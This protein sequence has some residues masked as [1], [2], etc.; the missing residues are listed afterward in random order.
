MVVIVSSIGDRS[1]GEGGGGISGRRKAEGTFLNTPAGSLHCFKNES[2]R[3]ATILIYVA[4]AG[5][6]QMFFEVGQPLGDDAVAA[7]PPTPQEIEKLLEAA[8][9]Y[10]VEICIRHR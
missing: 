2:D 9:R 10:D 4:P 6:E 7:P 1:G 3:P 5:L 8:P